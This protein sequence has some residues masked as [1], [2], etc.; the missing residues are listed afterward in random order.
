MN[1]LDFK[2]CQHE[3]PEITR[4]RCPTC[5]RMALRCMHDLPY[6]GENACPVC[7]RA[8]RAGFEQAAQTISDF[9]DCGSGSGSISVLNSEA[10]RVA[11][12]RAIRRAFVEHRYVRN[13]ELQPEPGGRF[14]VIKVDPEGSGI[15]WSGHLGKTIHG[16]RRCCQRCTII[17]GYLGHYEIGPFVRGE[18]EPLDDEAR[19]TYDEI[20]RFAKTQSYGENDE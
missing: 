8:F 13:G 2:P 10:I 17:F 3:V 12:A 9:V 15:D 19:R 4:D 7:G 18:L 11:A 16:A 20:E 6:E 1:N 5:R 14:K